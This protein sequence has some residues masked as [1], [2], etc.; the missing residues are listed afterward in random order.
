MHDVLV[1]VQNLLNSEKCIF[2]LD[3]AISIVETGKQA[4]L[5]SISLV[6]TG[7]HALAL[8]L[9]EC[10]FPGQKVFIEKHEMH[11]ACDAIVFCLVEQEPYILC[12]EMKSTEPNR[13]DAAKQFKS[14]VCFLDYLDSLLRTFHGLSLDG[15][16][17]RYFL[18]HNQG[19]NRLAK[20]PLLEKNLAANDAPEKALFW[21]V[22]NG[23]RMYLRKLVGKSVG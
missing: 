2:P 9:D 16:S 19:K 18:F 4:T 12:L 1:A 14:A 10:G 3:S 13:V 22:K 6:S 17:R 11:R 8:K 5:K 15:W 21:P 23:E 7:Q 20:P